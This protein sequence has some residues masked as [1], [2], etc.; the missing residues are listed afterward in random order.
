MRRRRRQG[1]GLFLVISKPLD[2]GKEL[3]HVEW[4]RNPT[5]C[6]DSLD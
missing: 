5:H 2:E 3:F 1:R 4:L 6:P